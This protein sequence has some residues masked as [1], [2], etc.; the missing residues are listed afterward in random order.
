MNKIVI[1]GPYK[2]IGGIS[3]FIKI[4]EGSQINK[5]YKLKV[6][7]TFKISKKNESKLSVSNIYNVILNIVDL[8][9]IILIEKVN[10]CHI[11]T[12]SYWGFYEKSLYV[13]IC[14]ICGIK[15]ILHIHGGGFEEFY[16]GE[17][18]LMKMYIKNILKIS[19]RVI[20]LSEKWAD[21]TKRISKGSY[22]IIIPNMVKIEKNY[23]KENINDAIEIIFVGDINQNK[24]IRDLLEVFKKNPRQKAILNVC[25]DGTLLKELS[26]NISS[27]SIKYHGRVN[28]SKLIAIYKRSQIFILPSYH[29]GLPF[30][31]LE[32]MSYQLAIIIT[33]VGGIPD[34][35]KDGYNGILIE[36][37]NKKQL[38]T[39]MQLLI[40]NQEFRALLSKNAFET[41]S[42][43]YSWES[44]YKKYI[45]LYASLYK[46]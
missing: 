21:F 42:N 18:R 31:M 12:S 25:G 9:D 38:E 33:S 2:K 15:T 26:Q 36:P 29:E 37:G 34:V 5:Y 43:E 10:I 41:V 19:S 23:V 6:L 30:A 32:A 45:K 11:N 28:K 16:N 13:I 22:I 35:I 20:V 3:E 14:R 44:G 8:I 7:D 46:R 39:K 24:G 4:V 27:E 1:I 17:N 40:D